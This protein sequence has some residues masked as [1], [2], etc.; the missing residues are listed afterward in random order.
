MTRNFDDLPVGLVERFGAYRVTREEVITF[1]R[2]F[3]PQP[4]HL[5]DDAAAK[6]I[7]GRIAASGWHTASMMM[8]MI[9]DHWQE[10]GLSQ[11]SIGGLGVDQLRW[12][13]PVYPGDV[14]R[15]ECEVVEATPSRSKP[16][17]GIVKTRT[18]A[19]NHENVAVATFVSTGM[20]V[21]KP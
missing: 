9:V 8:R 21:R 16:D 1:A 10:T 11:A 15:V 12:M 14:L 20:F 6:S 5:D 2:T 4:F 17:R 3:D 13:H 18:T 7:F 19:F